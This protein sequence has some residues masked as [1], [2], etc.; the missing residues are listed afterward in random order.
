MDSKHVTNTPPPAST[1]DYE[2]FKHLLGNR[3]LDYAHVDRLR[4]AMEANP[5]WFAARPILVNE[6]FE[7]IDGQHRIEAAILAHQPV[8][9]TVFSGLTLESARAMNTRQKQWAIMDWARSYA[10]SG[11]E[12]YVKFLTCKEDHPLLNAGVLV[13]ITGTNQDFGASDEFRGGR[14]KMIDD[15]EVEERIELF[16]EIINISNAHLNVPFVRSLIRILNHDDFDTQ[17]FL[18]KLR[19]KP[20]APLSGVRTIDNIRNIEDIY[21]RNNRVRI[22]LG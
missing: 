5:Q 12:D 20:D 21:N 7:V 17:A 4:R 22:R 13:I 1:T 19:E 8:Y 14:F 10:D 18:R 15:D 6:N 9:Y 2:V 11:I 16:Q 3:Q